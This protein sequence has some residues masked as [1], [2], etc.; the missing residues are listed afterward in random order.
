MKRTLGHNAGR[1]VVVLVKALLISFA[2][3]FV[4]EQLGWHVFSEAL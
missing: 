3:V 4:A 2:V 1:A